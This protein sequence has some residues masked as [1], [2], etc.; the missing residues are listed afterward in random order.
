[1]AVVEVDAN[2]R[3]MVSHSA[4]FKKATEQLTRTLLWTGKHW[5]DWWQSF[6]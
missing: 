3:T 1:M 4:V 5:L 6:A 2:T